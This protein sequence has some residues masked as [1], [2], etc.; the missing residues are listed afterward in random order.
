MNLK[1]NCTKCG[2][3]GLEEFRMVFMIGPKGYR[4]YTVCLGCA[5]KMGMPDPK[6]GGGRKREA[7]SG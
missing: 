6:R 1:T 7:V 2:R 3:K 5:K 4:R